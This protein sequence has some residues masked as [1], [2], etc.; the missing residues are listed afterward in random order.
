MK[1]VNETV[2]FNT[3]LT[4]GE[5]VENCKISV[6]SHYDILVEILGMHSVAVKCILWTILQDQNDNP[7]IICREL[8]NRTND[9]GNDII[10]NIGLF[11]F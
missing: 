7:V 11:D 5:I 4:V 1:A 3:R 10:D 2:R 8:F 9:N 6:G